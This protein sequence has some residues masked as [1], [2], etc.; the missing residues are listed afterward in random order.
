MIFTLISFL[1]LTLYSPEA[2]VQNRDFLVDQLRNSSS[3]LRVNALQKLAELKYPETIPNI[4]ALSRDPSADVR[5]A[6]I[7]AL[8][9]ISTQAALDALNSSFSNET[10]SYLK[11]E[12]RRSKKG[13]EDLL[14][15]ETERAEKEAAKPAKSPSKKK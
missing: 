5:F 11:S 7:Q 2:V 1:G 13:I 4:A 14:K 9:K 10:D 3:D 8:A 15:A 12:I 6:A